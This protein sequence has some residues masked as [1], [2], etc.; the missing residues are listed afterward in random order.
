M[1]VPERNA[2]MVIKSNG[3]IVFRPSNHG[4]VKLGGDDAA[5]PVLVG[6]FEATGNDGVVE[7]PPITTTMG[8]Q[9]AGSVKNGNR[10]KGTLAPGQ[11]KW[12]AKLLAK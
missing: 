2:A 6:D 4:Y 12:S 3:D 8:G 10:T 9:L 7:G 11:G 5:H 1:N